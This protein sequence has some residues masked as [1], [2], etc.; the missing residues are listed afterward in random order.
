MC[1]FRISKDKGIPGHV[2]RTAQLV[3]VKDAYADPN[4]SRDTDVLTKY[5][6]KTILASPLFNDGR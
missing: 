1:I 4:F 2:L 5:T 6:T 3:S